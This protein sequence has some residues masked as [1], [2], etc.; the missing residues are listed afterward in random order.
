M[1][2][3]EQTDMSQVCDELQQMRL[4]VDH[5]KKVLK[6]KSSPV[7]NTKS[8]QHNKI[9]VRSLKNNLFNGEGEAVENFLYRLE[10]EFDTYSYWITDKEKLA[11]AADYMADKALIWYRSN[12]KYFGTWGQFKI[13]FN[14]RFLP[15]NYKEDRVLELVDLK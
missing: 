5:L 14:E 1:S 9:V 10:A 11:T 13:M 8:N 4:E 2:E 7:S 15:P 12:N 3:E 6:L